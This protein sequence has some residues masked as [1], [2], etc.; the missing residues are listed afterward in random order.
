[1]CK[2]RFFAYKECMIF[3]AAII[4]MWEI[5]PRGGREWRMPSHRKSTGVYGTSKDTRVWLKRREL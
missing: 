3:A 1:M 2:G 4:A 5:E